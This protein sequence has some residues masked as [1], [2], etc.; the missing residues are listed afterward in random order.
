MSDQKLW[1]NV[2]P[3]DGLIDYY[4]AGVMSATDYP[5][6]MELVGRT[7]SSPKYRYGFNGK[8]KDDEVKG[9]GTQYDYGFRIYDP[10]VGRFLSVDPISDEYPELTPYQ[11]ASNG[12][13]TFFD[14]DGLESAARL[15]DGTIFFPAGRDNLGFKYPQGARLIGVSHNGDGMKVLSIVLDNVPVV[16]SIKG[17]IE[18]IA[19]YDMEGNKL[20]TGDRFLGVVPYAKNIKRVKQINKVVKAADKADDVDD[21]AKTA[22][23]IDKTASKEKSIVK[24]K[25]AGDLRE[26]KEQNILE[27][28]YP[29]ADVQN[30][31]YLRD[32]N[33]KIVKDPV[34]GEGRRIDHVV[35]KDG[36][37]LDAVETTSMNANKTS[38]TAKENRIREAGGTYVRDRK[39]RKLVDLKDVQTRISRH[40]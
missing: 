6:G 5:F 37:P 21:V 12:P 2:F 17:G 13:I 16:G 20:S 15:A 33:G 3:A 8:E 36:R 34:T 31:Q 32:I 27:N 1:V 14:R 38:Q 22:N 39:T 4:E 28:K 30:Q 40:D 29:G 10:R 25:S 7:Y 23:K 19:G 11:F 18:G 24:R 35:I 26:V 9:S